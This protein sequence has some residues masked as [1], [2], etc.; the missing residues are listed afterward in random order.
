[1]RIVW[2]VAGVITEIPKSGVTFNW[3]RSARS[4]T[5][6]PLVP[7]LAGGAADAAGLQ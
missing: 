6:I 7:G 2:G 1:M 4:Y 3:D 5:D